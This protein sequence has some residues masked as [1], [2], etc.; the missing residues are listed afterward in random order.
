MYA[1][2]LTRGRVRPWLA[3]GVSQCAYYATFGAP[4]P[5]IEQWLAS[6]KYDVASQFPGAL[7][8]ADMANTVQDTPA[9]WYYT[10]WFYNFRFGEHPEAIACARGELDRC[11]T[12]ILEFDPDERFVRNVRL[13]EGM[14][15]AGQSYWFANG[16]YLA[17]LAREVGPERFGRFWRSP[18]PVESAFAEAFGS[19]LTE[20]TSKWE[21][22]RLGRV[23]PR[24]AVPL[25][26]GFQGL[27]VIAIAFAVAAR[28]VQRR[29]VG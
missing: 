27:L 8:S 11:R 6:R 28:L 12:E 14:L 13:N 18:L 25:L 4:G 1:R 15:S 20:W 24:T 23:P 5:A 16:S 3:N 17:D 10:F 2:E 7:D 19:G 22:K 26:A 29:E 21:L 9:P